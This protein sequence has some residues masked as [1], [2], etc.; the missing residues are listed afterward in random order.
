MAITINW[1]TKVINVP[2]A[3]MLLIQ[4][5]PSEIRQLDIDAFRLELKSIEASDE[6]APFDDTHSHNTTVT[7]GGVSLARVVEIINGYTVTFEDGQYAVNLVGANS[8]IADVTNVNQVSVRSANSAGLTFS[9]EI[10]KQSFLSG[11]VYIDPTNGLPGTSFPRGTPSDRSDNYDDAK[12][13]LE[14]NKLIGFNVEG[15]LNLTAGQDA[16]DVL[17][18]GNGYVHS[19]VSLGGGSTD[20]SSFKNLLL[21]GS[22]SGE[23]F[24]EDC[25]INGLSNFRGAMRNC[26]IRGTISLCPSCTEVVSFVFCNSNVPGASAPVFDWNSTNCDGEFRF[27]AGGLEIRNFDQAGRSISI[28]MVAGHVKIDSSCTDGDIVIRG[29]CKV[30]DESAGTTVNTDHATNVQIEGVDRMTKLIPATL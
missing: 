30:T 29:N 15:V 27:Y 26:G 14:L 6:G 19:E 10:N 4:S 9:D 23:I 1:P 16:D 25:L 18:A 12:T 13:I 8:N 24:A 28:D 22:N 3:D 21:S 11:L 20:N 7:V 17:F 2:R 5:S